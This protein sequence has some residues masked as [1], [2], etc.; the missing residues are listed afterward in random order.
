MAER[1]VLVGVDNGIDDFAYAMEEL[2]NLAKA[3]DMEVIGSIAQKLDQVNPSL[4]VGPGKVQEIRNLADEEEADCI[5]F[6]D[7]L[8]PSQ[9]RNLQ[10]AI[11]HPVMDRTNLILD[12]FSQRARTREAK[13]QVEYAKL[14]YILPRLVGLH[15]ALSRQGGGSGGLS[16]KGAGEK[17][18]ELDR[19]KIERR[20]VELRRELKEVSNERSTQRKHRISS[21][22]PIVAIVGYTNAGKST[23]LN[24]I[25]E[26]YMGIIQKKVFE[27]DMLFATLD[28]SVRRIEVPDK[29]SFL[30]SDT[31]G[32]VQNLPHALVESFHSTLEEVNNADLL[33][34]VVD[35]SDEHY[36]QHQDVTERTLVELGCGNIP[37][38]RVYNKADLC[39]DQFPKVMDDARIYMSAR[40]DQSI[41]ALVDLIEEKLFAHYIEVELLLP[42]NKFDQL[43]QYSDQWI[44]E[45]KEYREDG[46]RVSAR[47]SKTHLKRI[48]EYRI[49]P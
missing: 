17:K 32:F 38:I 26:K 6:N 33:L 15:E 3:C 16:N 36:R 40:D 18:L 31:V 30:L 46:V 8:S 41:S 19:R 39:M 49:N 12:I 28:T 1:V 24:H 27:K 5:I 14:S 47:M 48:E 13:L 37:V 45:R 7:S 43:Y 22:L 11:Q 44:I 42:Y 2:E 23:I 25:L 34:H 20:M 10:N 9:I 35:Y 29:G 21:S 4:Y